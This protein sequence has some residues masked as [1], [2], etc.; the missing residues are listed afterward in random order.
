MMKTG[1]LAPIRDAVASQVGVRGNALRQWAKSM[2]SELNRRWLGEDFAERIRALS[3]RYAPDTAVD[4]D[5]I[6]SVAR[7]FALF[8][9]FYF[10][11]QVHGIEHVPNG[12]VIIVANHS[13]QIPIDAAILGCA[14]FFDSQVPRLVR[15]MVDRWVAQ[16]PFI[17]QFFSKIG[18]VVGTPTAAKELLKDEEA[19]L[20]FPEG[21][22]GISKPFSRRYQLQP[23]GHGFMRLALETGAP[24]LPVAVVGA[25]EQYINL[26]NSDSVARLLRM[27]VYPIIPQMYLPFGQLPLPTKYRLYFGEPLRFQG[28]PDAK[29]DVIAAQ[30]HVVQNA[31]QTQLNH[32]LR[33]RRGVFF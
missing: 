5:T 7:A 12:R 15:A 17:C 21:I 10:R 23:F 4:S 19:L 33:E 3:I 25:E 26:G 20:I 9:R 8:H 11:T 30:V 6:E 16:L 32:G 14:L 1:Q 22:R 24:I 27:P 18:S 31:I 2:G 13:G 29:P 28:R